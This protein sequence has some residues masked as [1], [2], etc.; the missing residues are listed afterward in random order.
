MTLQGVQKPFV[1]LQISSNLTNGFLEKNFRRDVRIGELKSKLELITGCDYQHVQLELFSCDGDRMMAMADDHQMLGAYPVEDGMRLHCTDNSKNAL[2]Y[3]AEG[4]EEACAMFEMTDEEYDKR[5]NTFRSWLKAN[6]LGRYR[7][8]DPEEAKREQEERERVRAQE[9]A[10]LA[11]MQRGARCEVNVYRRDLLLHPDESFRATGALRGTVMFAGP[12][13]KR[14]EPWIGVVLDEPFGM[15][16]G[17][18]FPG[19]RHFQCNAKYG[20]YVR[21]QA[22]T[23]GDFPEL[24][25]EDLDEI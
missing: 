19:E 16:D 17:T 24:G 18:A 9:L 13:G 2:D 6:K 15:C 10:H 12:V 20:L 22:I 1:K 7:E 25:I 21:P 4:N 3:E 11:L 8:V 23:V 5:P 14:P